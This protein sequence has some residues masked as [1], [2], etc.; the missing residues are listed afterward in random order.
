MEN[1]D[2]VDRVKI[3]VLAEDSV[4]YECPY[5]GQ[6]G[7]ALLME[8]QRGP[9]TRS[10]L[11]DVAQHPEALI[12]NMEMMR[13]DASDIDALVLTHCH[14][15]HTQGVVSILKKIGKQGIPVIAHP[16]IFRLHFITAPYLRHV[17]IGYNDAREKIE[18]AGGIVFLTEEPLQIVPGVTTTGEVTRQ[19]DF[20]DAGIALKTIT[21]G[22]IQEDPVLDDLS[23]IANVKDKGLVIL[24]GCSHAGIVNIAKHALEITQIDTIEGIIGGFHLIEASEEKIRKTVQALATLKINWIAA[25][26]C[27]GFE[28]QRELS[29]KFSKRFQPLRTGMVIEL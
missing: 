13:I 20:E 29:L 4:M 22:R 25:G 10:I 16:S 9:D 1:F 23:V 7:I 3:T 12:S 27:T 19:T 17:G 15:D 18:D 21:N 8:T 26:H 6:H 24:T 11:I 28:A 2:C 5:L 14:Y